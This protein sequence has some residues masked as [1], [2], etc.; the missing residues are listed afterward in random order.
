MRRGIFHLNC[1]GER[2]QDGRCAR[3]GARG[4]QS[5]ASRQGAAGKRPGIRSRP[6]GSSK[7]GVVSTGQ[8]TSWKLRCGD[9]DC[10]RGGVDGESGRIA[11]RAAAGI[12]DQY[13]K[14]RAIVGGRGCGRGVGRGSSATDRGTVFPPLISQRSS[15]G[16]RH[17]ERA[18]LARG[19]RLVYWLRGD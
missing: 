16:S 10:A 5:K 11:G 4:A 1:E 8:G 6:A 7:H 18:S 17:G 9:F 13:R 19:H 15:A 14:E 2:A 3:E 12:T